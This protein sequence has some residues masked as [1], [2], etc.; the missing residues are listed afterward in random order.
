MKY[1]MVQVAPKLPEGATML[2]QIHDE[3]LFEV[4]K[5]LEDKV[6]NVV[7]EVMGS[8]A[9]LKVSMIVDIKVGPNWADL[10]HHPRFG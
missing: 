10:Q 4:E 3:L 2:L 6:A 7:K 1:S 8:V 5:G 9:E